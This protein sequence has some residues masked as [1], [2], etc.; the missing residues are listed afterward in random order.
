MRVF[1][2][3]GGI[4]SGM[5]LVMF[6]AWSGAAAPGVGV[7]VELLVPAYFDPSDRPDDWARLIAAAHSR[8]APMTVIL[9]PNS[10]PGLHFHTKFVNVVT[11]L[12]TEG[13]RVVG[14]VHTSYATRPLADVYQDIRTYLTWYPVDGFF[15]DEMTR[16]DTP[17][18][19]AY[20]HNIYRFIK[21][22]NPRFRVIGNPGGTTTEGYVKNPVTDVLIVFEDPQANYHL[23]RPPSWMR[24]Y[25][26]SRFGQIV[27]SAP[28]GGL[29]GTLIDGQRTHAG[30][31]YV[32]D[33]AGLDG[34]A[35]ERL[36]VYWDAEFETVA[37]M[38]VR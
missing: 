10:G 28:Q 17:G 34:N 26:P 6:A 15:I 8:R 3:L 22:F 13:A 31:L 18:N 30:M 33:N 11:A 38:S 14:Y 36:P 16:D 23:F 20:Y 37:A 19:L 9:N 2:R 4:G 7:P 29:I 24:K 27:Y 25:P 21:G 32:T 12:R 1:W 35:Y 5:M